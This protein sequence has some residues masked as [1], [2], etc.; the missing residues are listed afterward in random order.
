MHPLRPSPQRT[1]SMKPSQLP[2]LLSHRTLQRSTLQSQPSA[3]G[4]RA[5]CLWPDGGLSATTPWSPLSHLPGRPGIWEALLRPEKQMNSPTP[6][7]V[8]GHLSSRVHG[9]VPGTYGPPCPHWLW[10]GHGS[11]FYEHLPAART[12]FR[13]QLD[14]RSLEPARLPPA[15][16]GPWD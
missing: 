13:S 14:I 16:P 7:T 10:Q 3:S 6:T 1:T 9:T 4:F 15:S 11:C 8:E 2:R 12:C 5:T